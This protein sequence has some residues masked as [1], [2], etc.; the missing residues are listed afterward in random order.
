MEIDETE[1]S[2]SEVHEY[3]GTAISTELFQGLGQW[4]NESR[5][6]LDKV[7][8]H[9]CL[10]R[11]HPSMREIICSDVIL[12]KDNDRVYMTIPD[13][14]QRYGI[15]MAINFSAENTFSYVFQPNVDF[16]MIEHEAFAKWILNIDFKVF[17]LNETIFFYDQLPYNSDTMLD[18]KRIQISKWCQDISTKENNPLRD[19]ILQGCSIKDIVCWY[20]D[21]Y[22]N[23]QDNIWKNS[24]AQCKN[25][26]ELKKKLEE[27]S[28]DKEEIKEIEDLFTKL[29]NFPDEIPEKDIND[30]VSLYRY[31]QEVNEKFQ[32][33]ITK[34]LQ[35]K[36]TV[37]V[38]VIQKLLILP[39]II[40][41]LR[42]IYLKIPVDY[43]SVSVPRDTLLENI[44][45]TFYKKQKEKLKEDTE[46]IKTY[47]EFQ[48]ATHSLL[49]WPVH[50]LFK[51]RTIFSKKYDPPQTIIDKLSSY[52]YF[53][54]K[55]N[56]PPKRKEI[57]LNDIFNLC[58]KI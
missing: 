48:N 12:V 6:D 29:D 10:Y 16:L 25:R 36:S 39:N 22:M 20:Y 7:L 5:Q 18:E 45:K 23:E 55:Y 3:N 52:D 1:N 30:E 4:S 43:K 56:E 44:L 33:D 27:Y 32:D 38:Y 51:L 42:N 14:P 17:Q 34:V 21:G 49:Q 35:N 11:V 28:T 8:N 53:R 54:E 57:S 58:T 37:A 50:K 47:Q 40:T 13:S 31:V 41:Q 15:V 19:S 24:I 9:Y 26:S 2:F 46:L